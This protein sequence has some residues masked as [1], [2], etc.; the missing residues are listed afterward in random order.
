MNRIIFP[1]FWQG[2]EA[3]LIA[4]ARMELD[5]IE[6]WIAVGLEDTAA[7]WQL[8]DSC[9]RILARAGVGRH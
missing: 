3:E 7:M 5:A 2:P 8:H 1:L 6:F 4:R 9:L